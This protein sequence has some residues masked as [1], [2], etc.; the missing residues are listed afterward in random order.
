MFDANAIATIGVDFKKVDIPIDG[1]N[2]TLVIWDTPRHYTFDNMTED[3]VPRAQA[4]VFVC[5]AKEGEEARSLERVRGWFAFWE[6]RYGDG[7]VPL[8][9]FLNKM[10][11]KL[12]GTSFDR[13]WEFAKH[14][15]MILESGSAKCGDVGLSDMFEWVARS[16]V[17]F[18]S[19]DA[20][21]ACFVV[22]DG[23][24]GKAN[25]DFR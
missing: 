10:D 3:Y 21:L 15:N 1:Q 19:T 25:L 20:F 5:S 13:A 18:G 7:R 17:R 9:L 4:I 23:R 11:L 6:T 12:D 24:A 14:R 16:L 22:G 8:A 2:V